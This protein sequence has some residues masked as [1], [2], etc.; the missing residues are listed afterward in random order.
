MS[1]QPTVLNRIIPSLKSSITCSFEDLPNSTSPQVR[2]T[3]EK[4]STN[5]KMDSRPIQEDHYKQG[6][7]APLSQLEAL[8]GPN[9]PIE[10]TE[11][12]LEVFD[13]MDV[14]ALRAS[15]K[16][17]RSN[18]TLER[19]EADPFYR[20]L[21]LG[22]CRCTRDEFFRPRN[23]KAPYRGACMRSHRDADHIDLCQT[24]PADQPFPICRIHEKGM[25]LFYDI[26]DKIPSLFGVCEAC[27]TSLRDRIQQ[28]PQELLELERCNCEE[29]L[30]S[31]CGKTRMCHHCHLYLAWKQM[32]LH[33]GFRCEKCFPSQDECTAIELD[34]IKRG[35]RGEYWL[36]TYPD[37]PCPGRHEEPYEVRNGSCQICKSRLSQDRLGFLQREQ[38][39]AD[40]DGFDWY[41]RFP[42]VVHRNPGMFYWCGLAG[43]GKLLNIPGNVP[44]SSGQSQSH[45]N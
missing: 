13:R 29:Q 41:S 14:K 19:V 17:I 31:Y 27:E 9:G 1:T 28:E 37:E 6:D 15:C 34:R 23:S 39:P 32:A 36:K 24:H 33:E 20:N 11:A 42:W 21:L 10:A 4:Q 18:L 45:L 26:W 25:G 12:L 40:D 2:L 43:C 35:Q 3:F 16:T 5:T 30:Y 22:F 44:R 7:A 38:D 8:L